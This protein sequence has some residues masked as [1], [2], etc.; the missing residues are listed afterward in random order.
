MEGYFLESEPCS[1][2]NTPEAPY[3]RVKLGAL[4]AE[5]KYTDNRILARA[6]ACHSIQVRTQHMVKK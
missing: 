2:C 5:V 1:S 4:K 3:A 6:T